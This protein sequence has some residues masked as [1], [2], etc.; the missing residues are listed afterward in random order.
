MWGRQTTRAADTE[1]ARWQV[2]FKPV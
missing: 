1:R 2:W